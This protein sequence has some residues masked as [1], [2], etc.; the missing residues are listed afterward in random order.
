MLLFA[1]KEP[2]LVWIVVRKIVFIG[3]S[4]LLG[5]ACQ[6]TTVLL[7][8]ACPGYLVFTLRNKDS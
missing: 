7:L 5:Q 4:K 1:L 8:S 2:E 3:H 6:N